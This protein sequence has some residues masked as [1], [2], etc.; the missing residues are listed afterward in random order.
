MST[1]NTTL[2]PGID[3]ILRQEAELPA[4]R[5]AWARW[6]RIARDNPLGTFG[7]LVLV[8]LMLVG[9][10][11]PGLTVKLPGGTTVL[12]LPRLAPHTESEIVARP[13]LDPSM[14][15]PFGTD[16]TGRDL[17][18]RVIYGAR[19]SLLVGFI[20][21]LGGIA[22][23]MFFGIVS[24]YMGGWTDNVIQRSVD[25]IIA[26]PGLIFLLI[27]VRV[28]GPSM[29]NVILVIM[30]ITIF[31]T[32]RIIRGATLS[33]RNNQYVEAARSI[34]ATSPRILF[35]HLLP[36]ILPLGIVLMTTGLGAAILA[37]SALSFLG[38]GI[39]T[40]N[41]SWGT[42]ISIARNSF[43]I[44]IWWPLFPGIAISLTVLGFNLLGD[45]IRDIADPRLRGSRGV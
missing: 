11:G 33:E 12:E 22:I 3:E 43:P 40:P 20:S 25:T 37:E 9:T 14:D 32:I 27:I 34:G 29:R 17:F 1:V 26:F 36:N 38:L 2:R 41:P 13:R 30:L 19:I 44:H 39:P 18:S 35:K 45:S 24:G 16:G 7:L 42:D 10:F 28:L 21:V 15:H 5:P 6:L 4:R 31:P 23:G 8:G